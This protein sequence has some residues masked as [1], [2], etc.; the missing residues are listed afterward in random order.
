MAKKNEKFLKN[1][2]NMLLLLGIT[3]A[4]LLS[5]ILL[6]CFS[7]G[8]ALD[9]LEHAAKRTLF[10]KNFTTQFNISINGKPLDGNINASV[11]SEER[12]LEMYMQLGTYTADY[13]CGIYDN[14][15]A[16][17]DDSNEIWA[18]DI[19]DRVDAFFDALEKNSTPDWALLLDF[20]ETDLYET[21]NQDFDFPVLMACL[22]DWLTAVNDAHWAETYAGYSKGRQ[23]GVTLY[24]FR[25]DPYVLAQ[26]SLPY[27]EKAFRQPQDLVD[28]KAYMEQAEYLFK[29]GKADFSFGIKN[30]YL[31][32]ADFDLEY[33]NAVI[34]GNLSFIGIGG[35]IVDT[36][37]I[38][39]Y[40]EEAKN[41]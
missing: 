29:D 7:G 20:E 19:S 3:A 39:F 23:D 32:S 10:A 22:G 24:R 8:G 18:T 35:T 4:V 15:F 14:K 5:V 40:I 34:S 11:D 1:K 13:I 16:V 28:L 30:G 26:A 31:V 36:E 41:Q 9:K 12:K 27:F 17:C 33:H 6:L 37:T 25:P 2:K 21:I 38:A